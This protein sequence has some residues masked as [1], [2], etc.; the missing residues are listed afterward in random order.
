MALVG[1]HSYHNMHNGV[2]FLNGWFREWFSNDSYLLDYCQYFAI[3][4]HDCNSVADLHPLSYNSR[5]K[6]KTAV[7]LHFDSRVCSKTLLLTPK[8]PFVCCVN[9]GQVTVLVVQLYDNEVE[10]CFAVWIICIYWNTR[11]THQEY[12]SF[13]HIFLSIIQRRAVKSDLCW[14]VP[15]HSAGRSEPPEYYKFYMENSRTPYPR[16]ITNL[17]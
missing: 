6:Q 3:L 10:N 5:T 15:R 1:E 11:G 4:Q 16:T 17:K 2:T 14:D 7:S 9:P 13:I 12:L 8:L